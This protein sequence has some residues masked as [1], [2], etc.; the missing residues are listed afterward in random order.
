MKILFH[1]VLICFFINTSLPARCASIIAVC[2]NPFRRPYNCNKSDIA[3]P[4]FIAQGN[5]MKYRIDRGSIGEINESDAK[6]IADDILKLWEDNSGLDFQPDGD[7]FIAEDVTETNSD[8]YFDN[9]KQLGYSPVIW[10]EQ[11]SLIENLYGK[12]S[13][14]NILG[15]A[16]ATFFSFDK[17]GPD[18][19]LEAHSLF[20]GYL[21]DG[22]NT[23]ENREKVLNAFKT[24]ILH[25]FGHMFG[26]DHTQG[27]NNEGYNKYASGEIDTD[28]LTDIPVMFPIIANPLVELQQ[29]DISAVRLGYPKGDENA[30]F[31][32]ITGKLKQIDS[33]IKGANVVAFLVDDSNPRKRAVACPSDVDGAGEGNFTLPN[34]VPG[35]YIIKAEALNDGFVGGSGVGIHN[36][37]ISE[38]MQARFYMGEGVKALESDDLETGL[39]Q[40]LK[41]NVEAG[42]T[43]N[44]NF[45]LSLA[46]FKIKRPGLEYSTRLRKF[47]KRIITFTIRNYYPGQIRR[48]R[49]STDHPDL[50]EIL[51]SNEFSF[52]KKFHTVKVRLNSYTDFKAKFPELEYEPISIPITIEDL[53]TGYILNSERF[54]LF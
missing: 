47:K 13:K 46:S 21:F 14:E 44:I 12:N 28:K 31:G 23:G 52:S 41:I 32:K 35:T 39:N 43:T 38:L 17:E 34:L 22:A 5:V 40:A 16:T 48:L 30:L 26:L 50:I 3:F 19:I 51:P 25:E 7:G 11:G 18:G 2:K 20:N 15:L 45:D 36:P 1:I 6:I 53:N 8:K 27:G 37:I 24:T 54:W 49:I 10:D 29:D 9:Q 4:T 42:S 33:G